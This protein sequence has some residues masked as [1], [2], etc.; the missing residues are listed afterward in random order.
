MPQQVRRTLRRFVS[1]TESKIRYRVLRL[2]L[3]ITSPL[4]GCIARPFDAVT[5][6]HAYL[7]HN[8][9]VFCMQVCGALG[10]SC[11]PFVCLNSEHGRQQTASICIFVSPLRHHSPPLP[12]PPLHLHSAG[13]MAGC[14][15]LFYDTSSLSWGEETLADAIL[16][17]ARKSHQTGQD[18]QPT[19]GDYRSSQ[20]I[21][22]SLVGTVV[23]RVTDYAPRVFKYIREDPIFGNNISHDAWVKEW[24]DTKAKPREGVLG[25]GKSGATFVHSAHGYYMIKTIDKREVE[26]QMES[27]QDYAQHCKD[28]RNTLLMRH[29]NLLQID[30]MKNATKVLRTKY[31]L[32]F[33]NTIAVP[34]MLNIPTH[35]WDLKGRVPKPGKLPHPNRDPGAIRKD[36]DLLRD[37]RLSPANYKEISRQLHKDTNYLK[38]HN[39][40]DYSLFIVV[41]NVGL[42]LDQRKRLM[43]NTTPDGGIPTESIKT[44]L[45][46]DPNLP[47]REDA[48]RC[49]L[50]RGSASK[51]HIF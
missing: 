34:Q 28:N 49:V 39:L 5:A 27:L 40:M 10:S 3:Y 45:R 12:S 2:C 51:L 6:N 1:K 48:Q 44:I 50:E 41:G 35:K 21:S 25:S 46:D 16:A 26:V 14:F 17:S 31:L 23:L 13:K 37:F 18:L 43:A 32:V 47:L 30:E 24:E 15:S 7:Q 9:S 38:N 42:S 36:K 8:T 4:P 11:Q 20:V 22:D 19:A 29:F 33:E